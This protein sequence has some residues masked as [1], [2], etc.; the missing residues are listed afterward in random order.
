MKRKGGKSEEGKDKL[1]KSKRERRG[2]ERQRG[3]ERDREKRWN[4]FKNRKIENARMQLEFWWREK[5]RE[6]KEREKRERE[7]RERQ[8]E[9]REKEREIT[10]IA[11]K[12]R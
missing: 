12:Y 7:K 8:R 6:R 1:I 11:Y 4:L 10:K 5:K 9:K 2:K 3:R